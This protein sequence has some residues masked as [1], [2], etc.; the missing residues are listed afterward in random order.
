M[1]PLTN[2]N[3]EHSKPFR[4]M[5]HLLIYSPTKYQVQFSAPPNQE[6]WRHRVRAIIIV[7][8][9]MD[10]PYR[11]C[12]SS[13]SPRSRHQ[14][15]IGGRPHWVWGGKNW[16]GVVLGHGRIVALYHRSSAL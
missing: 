12:Y 10:H 14:E 6:F 1:S 15:D 13:S 16:Q 4:D 9:Y 5:G 8:L 7:P 11:L 2:L 3:T